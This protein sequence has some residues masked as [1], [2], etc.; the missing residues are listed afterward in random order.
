VPF[1][2]ALGRLARR[3]VRRRV[4]REVLYNGNVEPPLHTFFTD[5]DHVV[6]Y[7][8]RTRGKYQHLIPDALAA[9]PG[10]VAVRLRNQAEVEAWLARLPPAPGA[11]PGGAAGS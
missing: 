8:I 1:P 7:M 2:V 3:T 4:R 10:L 9:H 6:R 11:R 5:R